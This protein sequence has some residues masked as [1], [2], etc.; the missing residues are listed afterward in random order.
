MTAFITWS[1]GL[2]YF[3]P[4]V[5]RRVE[6]FHALAKHDVGIFEGGICHQHP[7]ASSVTNLECTA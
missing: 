1:A 2:G 5:L 7:L 3:Q 6:L 4:G